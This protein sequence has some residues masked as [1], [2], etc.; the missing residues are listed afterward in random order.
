MP[1]L[2]L[3]LVVPLVR[4]EKG[5]F[6]EKK[7]IGHPRSTNTPTC[8]P[9]LPSRQSGMSSSQLGA[10]I[11]VRVDGGCSAVGV[12]FGL[13][14]RK[15]APSALPSF[16]PSSQ[17]PSRGFCSRLRGSTVAGQRGHSTTFF[18]PV[19]GGFQ[20]PILRSQGYRGGGVLFSI[21][22]LSILF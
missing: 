4:E 13:G 21:C 9:R 7:T 6:L 20:P 16:S 2:S 14:R 18:E 5:V 19:P 12:P 8:C 22:P 10:V 1:M 15:S 17:R 11:S 3:S